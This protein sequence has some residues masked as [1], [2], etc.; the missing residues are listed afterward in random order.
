MT[1]ATTPEQRDDPKQQAAPPPAAGVNGQPAADKNS[2]N[3]S[4]SQTAR[5][6]IAGQS[7]GQPAPDQRGEQISWI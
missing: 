2:G 6:V 1:E 5:A 7:A 3:D 4:L